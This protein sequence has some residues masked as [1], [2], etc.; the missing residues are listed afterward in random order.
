MDCEKD[1]F[2]DYTPRRNEEAH[3][4]PDAGPTLAAM[5]LTATQA[6]EML[7]VSEA[8][9]WELVRRDRLKC[10]QFVASGF[11]RP[12]RRFRMQDILQFIESSVG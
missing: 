8:T 1:A 4:A 2:D 10:V 6:S 5:L 11:Q 12:M 9:L 7:C 3:G